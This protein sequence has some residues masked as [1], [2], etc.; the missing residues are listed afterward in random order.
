[1]TKLLL[2]YNADPNVCSEYAESPLHVALRTTL[3]GTEGQ[4]DRIDLH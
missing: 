1:M 4:D 2:E 3:Y